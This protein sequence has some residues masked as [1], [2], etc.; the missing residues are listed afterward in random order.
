[1]C[2]FVGP[3]FDSKS[4]SFLSNGAT[5][6]AGAHDPFA[7]Q[8]YSGPHLCGKGIDTILSSSLRGDSPT[9]CSMCVLGPCKDLS[10]H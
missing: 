5:Q 8:E 9:D 2:V 10:Y 6:S 7:K 3:G 1:M 4:A